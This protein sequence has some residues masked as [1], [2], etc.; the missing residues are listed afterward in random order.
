[1][2]LKEKKEDIINTLQ[3]TDN[4]D[5][6]NEV[7]Q[8]LHSDDL[9]EVDVKKLPSDLQMKLNRA[10]EDYKQGRY[11]THEQMQQKMKQWL[12]K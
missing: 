11:I 8:L 4:E 1:M 10:L 3:N 6:I 2:H 5:L 12:M 7:Y 9:E